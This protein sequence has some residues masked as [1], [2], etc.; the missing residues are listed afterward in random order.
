MKIW[1]SDHPMNSNSSR[2]NTLQLILGTGAFALCFAVFGSVS[3]MMPVLKKAFHLAPV[4]ASIAMAIPV[5]LGSLGRIPLGLLTDRVGGRKVFTWTMIAS[6]AAALLMGKVESYPQLLLFGFFTGIALASFS[7]GVAFVSGWYPP[8]KQGFALG[9]YGAGNVGQSLAA[10][11]APLLFIHL[12]FRNTFWTFAGLLALWTVIFFSFAKDAPRTAPPKSLAQMTRPLR[13]GM[14]WVLSF[15]YFLTFG[16]F[17]AM[18]IY[19]PMF[20]TELFKLTPQDAGFRTAGFVLLATALRPV[21]GWLSDKVG[22]LTILIGIFPFVTA[23]AL[24]LT[25]QTMVPF[26]V[27]A[28]G[29][30]AAIGLGNGAVFKLVPQYFP[31]SVGAVTGL[32]GAMGGL[33][34]FFPPLA[35]GLIRQQT[36]SFVWGFVLL[37]CFALICLLVAKLT[38]QGHFQKKI[39]TEA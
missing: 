24:L 37:G 29:M 16:G 25:F 11:G 2:S 31:Q 35:L 36:G 28:L 23:M 22:G 21:G 9:V 18:S 12:G 17:V 39:A 10:F 3:A 13:E 5:L 38:A 19:L 34:G 27:G 4:Q 14:S 33:G 32:V 7:V 8:E 1:V 6:V 26:T 20:L 15:F 30:A